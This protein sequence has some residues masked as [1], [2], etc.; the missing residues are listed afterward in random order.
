MSELGI[1]IATAFFRIGA[2]TVL[3]LILAELLGRR[4][5]R[6]A[7]R[8]LTITSMIL[9]ALFCYSLLQPFDLVQWQTAIA[10]KAVNSPEQPLPSATLSSTKG[11]ESGPGLDLLAL[12]SKLQIDA[13]LPAPSRTWQKVWL[14]LCCLYIGAG[15]IAGTK[16]LLAY[17]SIRKLQRNSQP[18]FDA[19][20]L[21]TAHR[22]QAKLNIS[23]EI[24][25]RTSA[26][27]GLAA[28][29]GWWKPMIYLAPTW[30]SWTVEEL[31]AVL[32]HELV[33]I[34]HKDFLSLTLAHICETL[35]V[36]QPL[37]KFLTQRLR[38]MQELAA[39][40][41]ASLCLANREGYIRSLAGLALHQTEGVSLRFSPISAITGGLLVRRIE[42]LLKGNNVQPVSSKWRVLSIGLL[43]LAAL[44]STSIGS[45]ARDTKVSN[46]RG[47]EL[48]PFITKYLAPDALGFIAVR[49]SIWLQEPGAE[50]FSKR[51]MA[52]FAEGLKRAG[53]E[54]PKS[55]LDNGVEQLVIQFNIKSY[56]APNEDDHHH[57]LLNNN[58]VIRMQNKVDWLPAL[59]SMARLM[60][61]ELQERTFNDVKLYQLVEKNDSGKITY[62]Y[63][64]LFP[65]D[66]TLVSL[67]PSSQD[68]EK[69]KNYMNS[70]GTVNPFEGK[71]SDFAQAGIAL[72]LHDQKNEFEKMFT[73]GVDARMKPFNGIRLCLGTSPGEGVP[74]HLVV[75]A[76]DEQQTKN[77]VTLLKSL[78]LL[79]KPFVEKLSGNA[80]VPEDMRSV[81]KQF[82]N[83]IAES[84]KISSE[85][86][87][88]ECEATTKVRVGDYLSCK[89]IL[90]ALEL[91][92]K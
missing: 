23:S 77:V 83:D 88:I 3:A 15:L 73:P 22:L 54:F 59:K 18:I 67:Y 17:R 53:L 78:P 24:G 80:T 60:K 37:S 48:S 27:V 32:T 25:Y 14:A 50:E 12:L 40:Q 39:D 70:L 90:N 41:R 26:E 21:T 66:R 49:P 30:N 81:A 46:K 1:Q 79:A 7:A 55:I 19:E 2:I 85:K 6:A 33:H 64:F 36:L 92:P 91:L 86:N 45:Q 16:L 9:I 28:T 76:T 13:P 63:T 68:P 47:A 56:E 29:V 44:F 31:S 51:V 89:S 87:V 84:A 58:F 65:D 20:L 74:L 69:L 43:I 62:T 52:V 57:S 75:Q 8:C 34:A 38:W 42:M 82:L 10:E 71:F 4:S 72:G 5:P 35:N 11:T 61:S